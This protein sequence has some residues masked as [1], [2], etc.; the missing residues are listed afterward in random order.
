MKIGGMA[1]IA[2]SPLDKL[3]QP[4]LSNYPSIIYGTRK[5]NFREIGLI[6]GAG[7]NIRFQ[8]MQLFIPFK[9]L[10]S[11]FRGILYC[12]LF[13][14]EFISGRKKSFLPQT[15]KEFFAKFNGRKETK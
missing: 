6:R 8:K 5:E 14:D 2:H 12:M 11:A 9:V 4:K 1:D 13:A 3:A 15:C 7:S 10:C